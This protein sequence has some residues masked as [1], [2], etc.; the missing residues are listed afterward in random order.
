MRIRVGI[1]SCL[2]GESVRFDGGHKHLRLCTDSLARFF[3]F[4][5]ECPEVGIGMGIPRK[6]IRLV[7]DVDAPQAID[8]HDASLN[9]TGALTKFGQRKAAEHS[10]LSGYIFTKNS[11]SCG[12]FRVKV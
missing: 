3:E 1:S 10:H 12:L 2:L 7:G 9:Y 4:V 5:S 8:V 6:P 11:P